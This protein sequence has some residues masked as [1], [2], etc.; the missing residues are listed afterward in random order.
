MFLIRLGFDA[1]S[2]P[3]PVPELHMRHHHVVSGSGICTWSAF[4]C[5]H[6]HPLRG[7]SPRG[8]AIPS[9]EGHTVIPQRTLTGHVVAQ[10]LRDSVPPEQAWKLTRCFCKTPSPM[11]FSLQ[12]WKTSG[13]KK[14][15]KQSL[16]G[17]H[18]RCAS[19][20]QQ[21]RDVQATSE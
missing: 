3:V 2:F 1:F 4:P 8:D 6:L 11:S 21:S 13:V 10:S 15:E 19:T 17:I 12:C 7:C 14:P 20:V 16:V 9:E 18:E 5:L